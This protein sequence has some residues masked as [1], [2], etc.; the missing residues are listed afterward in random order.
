MSTKPINERQ[1]REEVAVFRLFA[2]AC[3]LP[4]CLDSIQSRMP[5]EP[6][7]LCEVTGEGPVAFELVESIDA[8]Y[9]QQTNDAIELKLRFE[10]AYNALPLRDKK[11]LRD[12]YSDAL[13]LVDFHPAAKKHQKEA[14]VPEI[15][16]WLKVLPALSKGKARPPS[17]SR[18]AKVVRKVRVNRGGFR[19]PQFDVDNVG[20]L[21]DS[22]LRQIRSKLER[23]K[24]YETS[25]PLELLAYLNIQPV[26]PEEVWLDEI[27]EYV[28][29]HLE[30][31]QFRRVWILDAGRGKVMYSFPAC[32]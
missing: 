28:S 32:S 4:V 16:D 31:S 14:A 9:A 30:T 23:K 27:H 18:L 15:L 20:S 12:K 8:R 25:H 17:G 21:W 7:I 29:E 26:L 3:P 22:T 10:E 11:Q 1:A 13:I 19:G 2:T 24:P 5:P 6:D